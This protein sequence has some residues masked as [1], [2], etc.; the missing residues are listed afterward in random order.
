MEHI[1]AKEDGK[2]YGR[3][4]HPVEG[5]IA[6]CGGVNLDVLVLESYGLSSRF[7]GLKFV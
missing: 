7:Q 6:Q 1:T 4:G 5:C 2:R 3:C